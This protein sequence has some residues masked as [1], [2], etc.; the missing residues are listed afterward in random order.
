MKDFGI[1]VLLTVFLVGL[2]V[3]P[4][5]VAIAFALLGIFVII[6]AVLTAINILIMIC[7]WIFSK[8]DLED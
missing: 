4:Y 1:G 7:G 6:V 8:I 5:V 2:L 3:L